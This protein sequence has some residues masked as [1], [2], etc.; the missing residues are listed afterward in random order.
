M[1]GRGVPV[2]QTFVCVLYA[3]SLVV[4][5]GDPQKMY[6]PRL[7]W[8]K[9]KSSLVGR[10]DNKIILATTRSTLVLAST[11]VWILIEVMPKPKPNKMSGKNESTEKATFK[12]VLAFLPDRIVRIFRK[13]Q[14][15]APRCGRVRR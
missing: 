12:S 14:V 13:S 9:T 11:R 1:A 15:A 2:P 6:E 10:K 8:T 4:L 5:E 3:Y 7:K